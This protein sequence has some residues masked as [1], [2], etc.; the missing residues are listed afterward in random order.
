MADKQIHASDFYYQDR[1]ASNIYHE[2][3]NK[4]TSKR[5]LIKLHGRYAWM[6]L[7][8]GHLTVTG[9]LLP[10]YLLTD[11]DAVDFVLQL[12]YSYELGIKEGRRAFKQEIKELL[13]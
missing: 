8:G 4:T 5:Q 13:L 7:N 6:K 10:A 11:E 9:D 1:E 2:K 12:T 3:L